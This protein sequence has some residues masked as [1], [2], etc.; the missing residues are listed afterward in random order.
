MSA[1]AKLVAFAVAL[2]ALFAVG[3]LAGGWVDPFNDAGAD[4]ADAGHGERAMPM[5]A[6]HRADGSSAAQP[7]MVRGLGIEQDGLRLIVENPE[8][9][10][11]QVETVR[12]RVVDSAGQAVRSFDVQHTKRMH[13]IVA[14]RDLSGFQHLHPTMAADGTW[15]ASLSLAAPGSYRLFADFAHDGTV[16]TLAS[17]LR[18]DGPADLQPLPPAQATAVSDG[19]YQVRLQTG[20]VRAGQETDLRFA[21]TRAGQ[22]VRPE[23]YLGANGHLVALRDGD[24]AFLHVH[25]S[26]HAGS[27]DVVEF[28]ATFPTAGRYRLFLQFQVGGRVQTVAFTQEVG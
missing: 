9:R 1:P 13:L 12:F 18:V 8:L 19:G 15:S 16:E 22:A 21:V 20:A 11:G 17:D 6:D 27:D 14:R 24:M 3:A 2:V 25:P 28:M 10:R 26:E 5:G 23:P 7:Q 4:T